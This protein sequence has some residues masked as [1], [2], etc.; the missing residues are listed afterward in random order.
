MRV[1]WKRGESRSAWVTVRTLPFTVDEMKSIL[2][3]LEGRV[4]GS[5][6]GREASGW[7]PG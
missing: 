6:G 7:R 1:K 5:Q 2:A 4:R 3:G